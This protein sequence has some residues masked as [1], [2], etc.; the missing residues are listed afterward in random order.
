QLGQTILSENN[1]GDNFDES[2]NAILQLPDGKVLV[3]ATVSF[4]GS[5]SKIGLF[6]VTGDGQL[7]E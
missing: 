7:I 3:G 5:N 6:K 2:G 1:F 4:G